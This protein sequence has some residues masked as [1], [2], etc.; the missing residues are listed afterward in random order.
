MTFDE[1]KT[2]LD[3]K[4][5]QFNEPSFLKDDPLGIVHQFSK[6]ED[7]EIMGLLMATIAWGNRKSI[8][9]SGNRLVEIFENEP[10]E[11]VMNHKDSDF[12]NLHFVHRTFQKSDLQFFVGALRQVYTEYSS[13]E[14]VFDESSEY[15]GVKGRIVNFRN[16]LLSYPHEKRSEKHLANPAKKSAAK[17][18]NMYLRWMVRNDNMGVDFG[19]WKSISTSELYL[20]LDIH[21]STVGRKLGLITRKQD[22]WQ[23]LEELMQNLRE[24]DSD[25]P[26]KYDFA[27][28]GLG[29]M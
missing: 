1:L 13:L 7:I 25:D 18:L 9:T 12:K 5:E 2:F 14:E 23:A 22:D 3:Q 10:F 21:T 20:P 15:P 26:C 6:K 11:F 27:L 4:V 29:V 28:F 16:V 17:R 24:F 19:I 8:I